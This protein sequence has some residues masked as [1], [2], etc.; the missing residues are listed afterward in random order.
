MTIIVT[1]GGVPHMF[2][3]GYANI[4]VLDF[5]DNPPV[6]AGDVL[7]ASVSENATVGDSFYTVEATDNDIGSNAILEYFIV[8]DILNISQRFMIN[9]TPGELFTND[10]FD[11]ECEHQ[12]NITVVAIDDGLIPLY[13][14][15]CHCNNHSFGL[16]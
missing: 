13:I 14:S 4:T 6:F 7:Q 9:Q 10:T 5:N 8:E 1:D 15:Q 12:L 2:G 3:Y 11:L 16:E